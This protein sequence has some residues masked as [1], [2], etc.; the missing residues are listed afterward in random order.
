MQ[1]LCVPK[2]IYL[3]LGSYTDGLYTLL[4]RGWYKA[5]ERVVIHDLCQR[6]K[7]S[8]KTIRRCITE[9]KKLGWIRSGKDFDGVIRYT[10]HAPGPYIEVVDDTRLA[11]SGVSSKLF[12]LT[13]LNSN[14]CHAKFCIRH[15]TISR[16]SIYSGLQELRDLNLITCEGANVS[17]DLLSKSLSS[18]SSLLKS[19]AENLKPSDILIYANEPIP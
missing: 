10:R 11:M 16:A 7:R 3:R 12:I 1:K 14:F 19:F 2:G 6:C 5:G 9:G 15:L 13:Q 8:V 17:K 4:I 18:S